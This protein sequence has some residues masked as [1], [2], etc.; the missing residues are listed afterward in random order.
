MNKSNG[1]PCMGT[2]NIF[3]SHPRKVV[4]ITNSHNSWATTGANDLLEV[5]S[6]YTLAQVDVYGWY[7]L[8]ELD[9]FPGVYFNSVLFAEIGE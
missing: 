1:W 7:T 8:I 3:N 9:E 6:E 4:C 2:M 5:G